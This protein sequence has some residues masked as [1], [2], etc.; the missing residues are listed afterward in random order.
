VDALREIYRAISENRYAEFRSIYEKK[1][2]ELNKL[3]NVI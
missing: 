1:T 2:A 3:K